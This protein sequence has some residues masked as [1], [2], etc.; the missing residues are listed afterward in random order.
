MDQENSMMNK[1]SKIKK[2]LMNGAY[3]PASIV[4]GEKTG[5]KD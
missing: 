2:C 3:L 5:W 4:S 1:S